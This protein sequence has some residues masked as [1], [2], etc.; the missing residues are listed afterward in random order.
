MT[1]DLDHLRCLVAVVDNGGFTYAA[2][3]L[4]VSQPAVSR[5]I[6]AL[7]GSV[8]VR[9]LRRNSQDVIPTAAGDRVVARARR[10]LADVDDLIADALQGAN[11]LRIGHAGSTMGKH[12]VAFQ[13]RWSAAHPDVELRIVRTPTP[14]GGLAER[15]CDIAVLRT[16]AADSDGRF[17]SAIVGTESR[18]CAFAADDRLAR[19]R[20]IRLADVSDRVLAVVTRIGGTTLDLWPEGSRPAVKETH[21]IDDWLDI[22]AAGRCFGVTTE[23]TTTQYRRRGVVFRRLLDAPPVPIRL[24]WWRDDEHPKTR[25]VVGLLSDLYSS[26][27]N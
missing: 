7:E 21:E 15:A 16:A 17:D 2:S 25:E 23:S 27:P 26:P 5:R 22:I 12:T 3:E 6:S 18:F 24:A 8:G 10:L 20:Q 4:G 9:L 11:T 1:L 19:R 13:H 14:T